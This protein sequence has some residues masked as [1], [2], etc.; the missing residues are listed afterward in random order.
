MSI[1]RTPANRRTRRTRALGALV[2][3]LES[4]QL[5]SSPSLQAPLGARAA[6]AE[7][8]RF[9]PA[10]LHTDLGTFHVDI[11]AVG[12]NANRDDQN[13]KTTYFFALQQI[14][15]GAV[16]TIHAAQ[17]QFASK[18]GSQ[19]QI[20]APAGLHISVVRLGEITDARA[21]LVF[22]RAETY[23]RA[24]GRRYGDVN[25]RFRNVAGSRL[26]IKGQFV[27]YNVYLAKGSTNFTLFAEKLADA[28]GSE[29][30]PTSG[31]EEGQPHISILHYKPS[32]KKSISS[33]L[34]RTSPPTLTLDFTPSQLV[35]MEN[36]GNHQYQVA[37]VHGKPAVIA[38]RPR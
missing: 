8:H 5:L 12:H 33:F 27:S 28:V 21:A 37:T 30:T 22:A 34:I 18:F 17:T 3:C 10:E 15:S 1:V 29:S 13:V 26:V 14:P 9:N 24:F 23:V 2:D 31:P 25:F 20:N 11:G 35:L 16:S 6:V 32:L 36:V 7:V 19:V 38:L 4:R